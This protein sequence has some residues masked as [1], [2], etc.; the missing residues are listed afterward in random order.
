MVMNNATVHVIRRA[1]AFNPTSVLKYLTEWC[2]SDKE[3]VLVLNVDKQQQ[4]VDIRVVASG[5][6]AQC[7]FGYRTIFQNALNYKSKQ[8][9]VVHNHPSNICI[10][11]TEDDQ[12]TRMLQVIGS[13]LGIKLLDH[14]I[15]CPSG[16]YFSYAE[17]HKLLNSKELSK[18][19]DNIYKVSENVQEGK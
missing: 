2:T 19:V 17:Q 9:I 15:L 14:I 10:S 1:D 3:V 11:S 6:K 16:K 4:L 13:T 12:T 18:I 8:L 7:N 5:T